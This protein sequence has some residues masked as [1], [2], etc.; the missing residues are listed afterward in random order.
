MLKEEID[1]LEVPLF[2]VITAYL[3]EMDA[4][5]AAGYWDEMTEFLLRMSL[6]VEVK[7]RLLLP[8][9]YQEIEDELT[10]E[11]ARDQL[12]ARLFDY[13]K[14]RAASAQLR[15]R[16]EASASSVYRDPLSQAR[17]RLAPLE[18]VAG[19]EDAMDLRDCLV[20]LLES[21]SPP[22][23][24]H[25]TQI[26]VELPRQIRIIRGVLAKRGHFSFNRIFGGEQPLVQALSVFALLD[27]LARG[28]IRVSQRE[29]FG[30]I[31]VSTREVESRPEA[32]S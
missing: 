2:E 21:K 16:G 3:E 30:D 27:L 5:G 31:H 22:D 32:R 19:T 18:S 4:A 23:T 24:S 8:G 7:S 26:K 25:I 1:L 29:A 13:S 10:P 28:E 11:E 6:L 20:R 12:L 14:F 15:E 9:A 17:R